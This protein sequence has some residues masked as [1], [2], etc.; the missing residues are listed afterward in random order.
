[1]KYLIN[2]N[3]LPWEKINDY[4]LRLENIEQPKEICIEATKNL[5]NLIPYD[6]AR[7]YF[8]NDNG[9]VLDNVLFNVD[10]KWNEIYLKYYSKIENGRYSISSSIEE[11][12]F[13]IPEINGGL[14]NWPS[15][16][17]DEFISNYIQPQGLTY[18]LGF[19][20]IVSDNV[21]KCIFSLDRTRNKRYSEK[22]ISIIK[23]IQTHLENFYGNLFAST[24]RSNKFFKTEMSLTKREIEIAELLCKGMTPLKIS[25]ELYI[26]KST[27]YKHIA[28][29]HDK[30]KVSNRQELILKLL[31]LKDININ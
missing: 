6:Q 7:I 18:C 2:S 21:T 10:R 17:T 25:N 9:I 27:V 19:S 23:I 22:E 30:L 8:I 31:H 4:L 3:E 24:N 15:Y 12:E 5:N 1:M 28:N 14:R 20:L 26:S 13:P 16:E 29:M 11:R